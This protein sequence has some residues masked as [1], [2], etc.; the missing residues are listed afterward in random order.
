MTNRLNIAVVGSGAAGLGAAWALSQCHRVTLYEA[1]NRPGGHSN[2]LEVD[3]G[4]GRTLPVDT[5]FI[6]YN[7]R[8]YPNLVAW[9]RHLGVETENSDMSFSVQAPLDRIEWSGDNL[10]TVFGQPVNLARPRFI[11]MVRDILR[12]NR[13]ATADVLADRVPN[14]SLGEYLADD[15]YGE[16]FRRWYLLPMGAAIWSAT[17][18]EMERFPARTFLRFFHNHGL[19]TVNDR[20]QWRTVTGGS[21]SYVARV[22]DVIGRDALSLGTPIAAI[23]RDP[24]GAH[25]IDTAGDRRRF[26]H[27]VLACHGDQALAL[28]AEPSAMERTTLG[29]FGYQS[30][31]AVLHTDTTLMP[32][33]RRLWASWNYRAEA[34]ENETERAPVS[35]TYWMNRL[36]NLPKR[37]PL[38]VTLNP[39]TEPSADKVI[40]EIDYRHPLFDAGAIAAQDRLDAIQGQ[41]RVWFCGSYAGYGF[42]EDAF[43][44]GLR[45]AEALGAVIPWRRAGRPRLE[46]PPVAPQPLLAAAGD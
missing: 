40:A 42:H 46:V 38:F 31:R 43:T 8:N 45:V 23:E 9:F 18:A 13:R 34:P 35:L 39:I 28:L 10:A 7:E 20:P 27:V 26:D 37:H 33:R 16:G 15:G 6:V 12:F 14:V 30:N 22:L 4:G 3:V 19:L 32:R 5:G 17:L 44:S 25:V 1:E 11:A 2:T 41:Q 24:M 29:A 21:R 36:Q